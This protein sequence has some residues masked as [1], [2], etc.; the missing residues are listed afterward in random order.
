MISVDQRTQH[1]RFL[2]KLALLTAILVVLSVTPVGS[3]PLPFVKATTSHIPVIV[4]AILLGPGSGAFLGGV[5]G[6]MSVVRSTLAP[7]LT[8]FVFSPFLPVP[9]A[10][11]GSAKAL[12]VAFLPRILTGLLPGLLFRGLKRRGIGDHAACAVCGAVGAAANTALVLLLIYLL[13]GAEYASALGVGYELLTLCSP[14]EWPSCSLPLRPQRRYAALCFGW[15]GAK[16]RSEGRAAVP[17]IPHPAH[18]S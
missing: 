1:T 2:T 7:T 16:A 15:S 6:V 17:R 3:I 13:F 11:H 12:L 14:T 4:G 5:F 10:E 9:G 18:V 8:T